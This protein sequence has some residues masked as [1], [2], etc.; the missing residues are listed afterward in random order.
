MI[1]A[2]PDLTR[3][4]GAGPVPRRRR[5][6]LRAAVAVGALSV[7]GYAAD[8]AWNHS[9]AML[10]WYDLNVYNHAG[11]IARNL[12]RRLYTWQLRPGIKF[13]YTPFAAL[14]FAFGSLLPW[15]VLRWLMTAASL[16]AT[17]GTVWLTLGALG[18]RG[19]GRVTAMLALGAAV[20]WIEPVQRALHLG[21][22]E[23]M[24]MLL[25]VWDLCQPDDRR[26]K[27][28]GIGLA[29]GIKLVPLIFIPYLILAGKLRQAAVASAAFAGSVAVGFVF[30]PQASVKWWLTGYLLHSGN[31]GDVGSLLNQSLFGLA[32]RAAGSRHTAAPIWLGL[33]VVVTAV[34]L[35]TAAALHR[36]GRPV[37][38]WLTCALT[39]LLVSPISWDHHWVWI[40]PV[41]VLFADAAVRAEGARRRAWAALTVAV[42]AI[43]GGW[44]AH[45]TGPSALV[46][47]GLLGFFIGPHPDHLKYHLRGAGVIS[48]NL[49]VL[50][51]LA[52]LALAVA[53]AARTGVPRRRPASALL[54]PYPGVSVMR[55]AL[56]AR[57]ARTRRDRGPLQSPERDGDVAATVWP[58][59]GH[60]AVSEA[61]GQ[62]LRPA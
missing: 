20:L 22:I 6:P 4:S 51:G 24:L 1:L 25:I 30:L 28:A 44:P 2:G 45:W 43:Y 57:R 12:P 15:V 55:R 54:W 5:W 17:G 7:A 40:V 53:G 49:Y 29:A 50:A 56:S 9:G 3:A 26:W 52:L 10:N 14:L 13:T 34:G 21:Q 58:G 23:L 16:A 62:P 27:G 48:W 11:L 31:V 42:A 47:Q 60:S 18:W 46:P 32:A 39:G 33:D 36:G 59:S 37:P 38:G 35:V 41:L 19:R 8:V 61:T